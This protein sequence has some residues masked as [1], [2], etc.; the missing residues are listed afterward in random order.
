MELSNT[1]VSASGSAPL[2]TTVQQIVVVI[3]TAL[4]VERM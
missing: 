1:F 3:K 4:A 2:L